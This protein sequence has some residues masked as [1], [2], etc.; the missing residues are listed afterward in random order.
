MVAFLLLLSLL[1]IVFKTFSGMVLYVAGG[2][3]ALLFLLVL[4]LIKKRRR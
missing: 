1:F 3:L 4:Y 2:V